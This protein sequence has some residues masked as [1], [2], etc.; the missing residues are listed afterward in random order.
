MYVYLSPSPS[1]DTDSCS[2]S[3]Q[4]QY[5]RRR[6]VRIGYDPFGY[7]ECCYTCVPQLPSFLDVQLT[8][9]H[10]LSQLIGSTLALEYMRAGEDARLT[11]TT[12]HLTRTP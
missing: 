1:V 10:R 7:L 12:L 5:P 2:R 4:V 3:E 8:S 6:V 11:F 9:S